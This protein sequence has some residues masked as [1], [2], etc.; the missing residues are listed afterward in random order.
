MYLYLKLE[1]GIKSFQSQYSMEL[2]HEIFSCQKRDLIVR[3]SG[4]RN[5]RYI[6]HK[7]W[8]EVK[9]SEVKWSEV[10]WN[11]V[12]WSYGEVLWDKSTMYIRV[13]LH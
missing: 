11:E 8:R 3:H 1:L 12:K 4:P 9:W 13:T 5:T 2:P 6:V 10:K 7:I